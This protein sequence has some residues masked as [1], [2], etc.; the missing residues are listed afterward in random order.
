MFAGVSQSEVTIMLGESYQYNVQLTSYGGAST[1]GITA[2]WSVA[3]PTIASVDETGLVTALEVGSTAVT[4]SLSNGQYISSMVT[5]EKPSSMI[6]QT[7][8]RQ[9]DGT[10]LYT[11]IE[12]IYYA[13]DALPTSVHLNVAVNELSVS[14]SLRLTVE[15]PTILRFSDVNDPTVNF[16]DTVIAVDADSIYFNVKPLVEGET[17]IYIANGNLKSYLTVHVGPVVDLSWAQNS[18]LLSNSMSVYLQDGDVKLTAYAVVTPSDEWQ[19]EDLYDYVVTQNNPDN[20]AALIEDFDQSVRGQISWT[21]KPQALGTTK[22]TVS[23]RGEQINFVLKVVDKER[24]NVN[25]V[26]ITYNEETVAYADADSTYV[27]TV[28]A[29]T[30]TPMIAFI[31]ATNPLNAAATWPIE[32]ASSNESVAVYDEA[33]SAFRLLADGETEISATS[34]DLTAKFNLIVKTEV[35]GLSIASGSRSTLMVG[36]TEQFSFLTTPSGL[37]PAVQWISSDTSVATVDADGLLHAVGV[38][39]TEIT[40]ATADGAVV[41]EPFSVTVVEPFGDYDFTGAAYMYDFNRGSLQIQAQHT[42]GSL[43]ELFATL[44]VTTLDNGTYTVGENMSDVRCTYEGKTAYITS[45]T[46]TV[47]GNTDE[48]GFVIDLLIELE[49]NTIHLSGTLDP[50]LLN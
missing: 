43:I 18:E 6:F 10:Y 39:E 3:D 35:T 29:S 13:P 49:G 33:S 2:V 19:R 26:S 8:T 4:A 40:V 28:N 48:N 46:I 11:N 27:G 5:V 47:T 21:I 31:A 38:G 12:D 7:A 9:T 37:S 1:E 36:E 25:S 24:V 20:P 34:H 45:G 41:S 14:D 50:D 42:G 16:N 17:R 44:D 30:A 22:M 23:S 32:W 15:D